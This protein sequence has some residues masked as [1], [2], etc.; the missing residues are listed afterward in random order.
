[1][2]ER[3][4]I[5]WEKPRGLLTRAEKEHGMSVISDLQIDRAFRLICPD[6]MIRE[7]FFSV[8]AIPLTDGDEIRERQKIIR[9]FHENPQLLDRLI[10]L[11]R[12]I[13]VTK[14]AWDSERSRLLQS[15]NINPTDKSMV[16][17]SATLRTQ[18]L[19]VVLT[20]INSTKARNC[21][22]DL[23]LSLTIE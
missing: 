14:N 16:L 17:W 15:K 13:A 20:P 9:T 2:A 11:V 5:L 22:V 3:S 8:L 10:D 1:M 7:S 4:T 12:R 23:T 18:H 19:S 21:A 6:P